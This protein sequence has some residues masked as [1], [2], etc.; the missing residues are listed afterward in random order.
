MRD[1]VSRRGL[2]PPYSS[3]E[4]S[5]SVGSAWQPTL[6][7]RP[8]RAARLM[9]RR[10]AGEL[11]SALARPSSRQRLGGRA[12]LAVKRSGELA[13]RRTPGVGIGRRNVPA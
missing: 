11:R 10:S 2:W 9:F 12:I 7:V 3:P 13:E 5:L 4:P 8:P 6:P 1:G